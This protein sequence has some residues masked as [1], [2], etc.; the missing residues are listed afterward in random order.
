[1]ARPTFAVARARLLEYLR[2]QGWEVKT[3]GTSGPLKTPHA[4]S[5]DGEVR[6]WFRPQA[7]YVSYGRLHDANHARSLWV[8][9]RDVEP[10]QVAL[11]AAKRAKG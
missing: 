8:D 10:E 3:H 6:L 7:V 1:M 4:T 11:I 2:S 5:Q 9:I